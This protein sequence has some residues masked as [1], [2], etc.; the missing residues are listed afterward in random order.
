M[1]SP[2]RAD[3]NPLSELRPNFFRISAGYVDD[4]LRKRAAIL[5]NDQGYGLADRCGLFCGSISIVEALVN[6]TCFEEALHCCIQIYR[7]YLGLEMQARSRQSRY[8]FLQAAVSFD[9]DFLN[10]DLFSAM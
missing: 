7:A 10:Q 2:Y 3:W 4:D 9:V 5:R 1:G 6:K 8:R